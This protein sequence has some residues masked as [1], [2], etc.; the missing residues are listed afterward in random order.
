MASSNPGVDPHAR[1]RDAGFAQLADASPAFLWILDTDG[2][3]AHANVAARSIQ[4]ASGSN[5]NVHWR[6]VWPD[7]NRFSVDLALAEANAGRPFRFRTRFHTTSGADVYLDTTASPIRDADGRI[8]RLLVKAEDVTGQ[9]ET[10]AFLNTV[11]DVLPLA[12]TVKD[13]RTGRYILANRAAEALFDQPDGL[14]GLRPADILPAPFA[15]WEAQPHINPAE[16]QSAVHHDVT[17]RRERWLSA[18]KVATYDDDGVRHVIGLTEDVTRRRR[19]D[20]ALRQA[21]DQARLAERARAAF[22]SNISHEL[23][24]PLNGVVA[25]LDLIA[26]RGGS[27]DPEVLEMIRASAA[28]LERRLADL[29][30]MAQLD[31]T[32][33]APRLQVFHPA[34]LLEA[35]AGRYREAAEAKSLT[36]D[37]ACAI[38]TCLTGDREC[39]E[40][41]LARLVDNAVKF[42]DRGR[43]R[44]SVRRLKDGR[45][46]FAVDD[47]GV[48]FDPRM[49][50]GLFEDFRQEDDSLTR[51]HGGL[52]LGLAI[53]REAA[54]R[55]GG[56]LDAASSPGGG[57]RF[58]LDVN[59]SESE[60]APASSIIAASRTLQVLV[61]DDHPTNRRIVELM[62][63][64]VAAVT[65]V[66]DG[67]AA[68]EAAAATHF[69][70][71]LM[72]IQMPRMDGITAVAAIRAAEREG[73]RTPIIMLTANTQA[74]HVAASRAAGADRHVGKPFTAAVLLD[75][76]EAVLHTIEV[77]ESAKPNRGGLPNTPFPALA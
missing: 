69:D 34:A 33:D 4:P 70:V 23:R 71:I 19:D 26:S 58:W 38:D 30:R 54:R 57:A 44:L 21:L 8:Q 50:D 62:L 41:A 59:L 60:A 77:A 37:V 49:K 1:A 24:T 76:I 64:G 14:A 16:L 65:S 6:E 48:G 46:R 36:I 55:L 63:H 29:M 66:E 56:V 10:A 74:E 51:R 52:G 13:A 43:I 11:I 20:D 47:Q 75:G 3:V 25:G 31:A 7:T 18:V 53:A 72:D 15:A 12:L 2:F 45:V 68:V 5:Q 39:L 17:L 73:A 40:E 28:A 9:V 35:L 22:L 67:Q 61:A 32:E 27:S 42:S